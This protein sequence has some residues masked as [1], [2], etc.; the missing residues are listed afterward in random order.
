MSVQYQIAWNA[1]FY[2][3]IIWDATQAVYVGENDSLFDFMT[4]RLNKW[5]Q[6][7]NKKSDKTRTNH[8]ALGIATLFHQIVFRRKCTQ[9]HVNGS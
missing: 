3:D 6:N 1:N 9:A 4:N 7:P 5:I 2:F 8:C